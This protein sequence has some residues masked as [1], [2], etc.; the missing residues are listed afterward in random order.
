MSLAFTIARSYAR[1]YAIAKERFGIDLPGLGFVMR[2][3]RHDTVLHVNGVKIKF[4]HRMPGAYDL[5]IAGII[6]EPETDLLLRRTVRADTTVVDVGASVGGVA[7]PVATRARSVFAFE[8]QPMAAAVLRESVALNGLQNI[9]VFEQLVGD[10][11]SYAFHTDARRPSAA[12]I[13][14]RGGIQS[15]QLD[16][17]LSDTEAPLILIIDVEGFEPAVL[18]GAMATIKRLRP[19]I[20]F[21]YNDVS[22]SMYKIG[23][24]RD[25]LADD[26]DIYRLRRDGRLDHAFDDA[27]NCVAVPRT[28]V[29]FAEILQSLVMR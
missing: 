1:V 28:S 4:D 27:W 7:L 6:N 10:G 29:H 3:I 23:D 15:V 5:M 21:E 16:D 17:V 19:L 11:E 24:V 13:T 2:R 9:R 25:L 8:P 14:G 12:G 22:R 26:Y 20:I 18:R